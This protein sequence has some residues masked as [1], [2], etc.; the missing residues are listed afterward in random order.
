MNIMNNVWVEQVCLIVLVNV[1]R[2]DVDMELL[3]DKVHLWIDSARFVKAKSAVYVFY[4]KSFEPIYIGKSENLQKEFSEYL[5]TNFET[6]PCLQK[7]HTYQKK[8]TNSPCEEQNHLLSQ[9]ENE[10]GRLPRCNASDA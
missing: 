8:F 7:T 5:D 2:I 1:L 10:H 6:R 4:D 3:E 9:F